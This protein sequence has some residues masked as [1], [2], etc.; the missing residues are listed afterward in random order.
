MNI[1]KLG[2][3]AATS[4]ILLGTLATEV[5]ADTPPVTTGQPGAPTV[6]CGTGDAT[7]MPAGFS[8]DGFTLAGSVYAGSDGT[9]SLQNSNSTAAVSQYDVACLQ[10]TTH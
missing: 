1:T 7:T 9:A 5:L 6:T 4:A 2:A 3:I 10:L 8:T